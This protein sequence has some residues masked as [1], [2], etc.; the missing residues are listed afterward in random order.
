MYIYIYICIS[1]MMIIENHS[2][3]NMCLQWEIQLLPSPREQ[4]DQEH[5]LPTP[6]LG[7]D[8]SFHPQ[9]VRFG[10]S[11]STS[12]T[13]IELDDGKIYRKA[14]YLMVKTMVS[15]RFSLK[16][17]QWHIP[18]LGIISCVHP[19]VTLRHAQLYGFLMIFGTHITHQKAT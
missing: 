6:C 17:I 18:F 3:K 14:L 12:S 5:S 10:A 1:S 4:L 11:S 13:F 2:N 15:C 8:N 16:P 7:M 9:L 19:V